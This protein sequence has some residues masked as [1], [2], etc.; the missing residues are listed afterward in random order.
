MVAMA[1]LSFVMYGVYQFTMDTSRMLYASVN[2]ID[3]ESSMRKFAYRLQS[4]M[5]TADAFYLFSS[6]QAADREYDENDI[7]KDRLVVGDNG[8]FLLLVYTQPQ[9]NTNSTV[10]I[11]KM[12]GYF[13][14]YPSS[15]DATTWCT[16]YR[17]EI[18]YA[19]QTIVAASNPVESLLT[20]YAYTSDYPQIVTKAKG[21]YT[22]K[23][24]YMLTSECIK[25]GLE[26]YRGSA[27]GN[28]TEL[29]YLTISLR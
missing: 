20:N 7:G 2:R 10:Y 21:L 6:F 19:D 17:L 12:V 13:R 5:E 14:K 3:V 4:D 9:P 22:N 23:M 1:I 18:D 26:Y 24:F 8:D 28:T 27:A 25:A 16:V 11:T 29:Q 15:G